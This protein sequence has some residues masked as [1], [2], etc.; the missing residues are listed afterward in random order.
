MD[1]YCCE[2]RSEIKHDIDFTYIFQFQGCWLAMKCF[3]WEEMKKRWNACLFE[4]EP[5]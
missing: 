5:N 1:K 4:F 3:W 2:N